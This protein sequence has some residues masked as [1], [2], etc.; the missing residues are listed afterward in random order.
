MAIKDVREHIFLAPRL[1]SAGESGADERCDRCR[2]EGIVRS[3]D[4]IRRVELRFRRRR[5]ATLFRTVPGD[6]RKRRGSGSGI[7]CAHPRAA[8]SSEAIR[9]GASK[10]R[11][12]AWHQ[13]SARNCACVRTCDRPTQSRRHLSDANVSA[14]F[15]FRALGLDDRPGHRRRTRVRAYGVPAA[16]DLVDL[17]T[18]WSHRRPGGPGMAA[19]LVGRKHPTRQEA[20]RTR[21]PRYRG[22]GWDNHRGPGAKQSSLRRG[23]EPLCDPPRRVDTSTGRN[24]LAP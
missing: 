4:G 24:R 21:G 5:T 8:L 3:G 13:T 1:H 23:V 19:G 14:G 9:V 6:S 15:L 10:D 7:W 18:R 16:S 22:H 12:R 2:C 20:E 11:A 17:I